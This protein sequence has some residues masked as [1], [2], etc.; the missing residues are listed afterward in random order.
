MREGPGWAAALL[1]SLAAC[2]M[3]WHYDAAAPWYL[4]VCVGYLAA[5]LADRA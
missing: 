1:C 4:Y 5:W 2:V 3:V